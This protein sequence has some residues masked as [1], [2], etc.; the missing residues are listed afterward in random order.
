MEDFINIEFKLGVPMII[1]DVIYAFT[2]YNI[3]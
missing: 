3:I 2:G 1:L